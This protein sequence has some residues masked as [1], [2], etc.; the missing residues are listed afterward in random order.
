MS[1]HS[2]QTIDGLITKRKVEIPEKKSN[3]YAHWALV[4][5]VGYGT[6]RIETAVFGIEDGHIR[7]TEAVI[8]MVERKTSSLL[9][10][11]HNSMLIHGTKHHPA[12]PK[13]LYRGIVEDSC[14]ALSP[15]PYW[16]LS[17]ETNPMRRRLSLW[18]FSLSLSILDW[19]D[20]DGSLPQ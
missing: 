1:D 7:K 5:Q 12:H 17:F 10:R 19:K 14:R 16:Y 6:L 4:C 13:A 11:H 2:L 18:A 9:K 20:K 15:L 8:P 3:C